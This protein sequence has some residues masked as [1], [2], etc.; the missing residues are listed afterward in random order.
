MP[1]LLNQGLTAIRDGIKAVVTHVGVSTSQE[2]F[3]ATDTEL[4][5]GGIGET[6]LIKV[7]AAENN[8]D[9][10]TAEFQI[11]IDGDIEF[12]GDTIWTIG[13]LDGP[14]DADAISRTVRSAGIGV[15][16]GDNYTIGVRVKAEDNTP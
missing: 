10:Q 14:L 11:S 8:I 6:N 7:T 2:V 4:D 5:G 12:T 16:A 9:F 3:D 1:A 15:Q 13:V